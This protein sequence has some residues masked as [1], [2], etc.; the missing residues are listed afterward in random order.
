MF[1]R[2]GQRI[3]FTWKS[4]SWTQTL[5]LGCF[6]SI[7]GSSSVSTQILSAGLYDTKMSKSYSS[8]KS[9]FSFAFSLLFLLRIQ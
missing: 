4:L 3:I 6:S 9:C 7:S 1:H 2:Y 8:F 5:S